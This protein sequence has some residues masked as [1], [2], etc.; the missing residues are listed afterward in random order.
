MPWMATK[1]PGGASAWR[2]ALNVVMPAHSNGAAS[3]G[4]NDSGTRTRPLALAYTISA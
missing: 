4:L 2:S 1:A 3:I